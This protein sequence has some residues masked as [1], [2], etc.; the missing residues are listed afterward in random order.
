MTA[1]HY[2]L[3]A[4]SLTE[5]KIDRRTRGFVVRA[6]VAAHDLQDDWDDLTRE[7]RLERLS[8]IR[9]SAQLAYEQ[10]GGHPYWTVPA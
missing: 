6:A 8:F 5:R 9:E 2:P 10:A 3:S 7:Q 1:R 4:R